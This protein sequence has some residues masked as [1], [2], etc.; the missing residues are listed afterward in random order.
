MG[1]IAAA[2]YCGLLGCSSSLFGPAQCGAGTAQPLTHLT[3]GMEC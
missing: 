1:I 3:T 2:K